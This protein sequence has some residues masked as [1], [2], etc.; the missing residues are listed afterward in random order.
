MRLFTILPNAA[1]GLASLFAISDAL[2]PSCAVAEV[3]DFWLARFWL[4]EHVKKRFDSE[5]VEIPLP[6]RT[7]VY[8]K[9]LPPAQREQPYSEK[10][11]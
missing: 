3:E 1:V 4:L 10:S 7:L 11:K 2:G 8:K 9:D 6:Y 5:G